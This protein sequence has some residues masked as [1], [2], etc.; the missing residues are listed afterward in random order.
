MINIPLISN[1]LNE[2]AELNS[3][4]IAVQ[5]DEIELT[6]RQLQEIVNSRT[7]EIINN[8]FDKNKIIGVVANHSLQFIIDLFAIWNVGASVFPINIT[9]SQ[10][11]INEQLN[12]IGCR[13]LDDPIRK[14]EESDKNSAWKKYTSGSNALL[15][16]TSGSTGQFKVVQHTFQSLFSSANSIDKEI[17]FSPN[18]KWLASLPFYRIGGFQ[19]IMRAMLS[20]GTICIPKQVKTEEINLGISK[21][22]P[23]YISLV[24]ASIPSLLENEEAK[25]AKAIFLGG[26]PV[27]SKILETGLEKSLP[28][29]KVYGSTET[30]SMITILNLK[31]HK[32]KID[33]AGQ[34]VPGVNIKIE[35]D[36]VLV[37]SESLFNEYYRNHELTI[38]RLTGDWYYT[39]DSG[40]L[41]KEGFLYIKGRID[42]LIVSGG[43]KIDPAEI[44]MTLIGLESIKSA[45]VFGIPDDKWGEKVCAAILATDELDFDKLKKI[46][47]KYLSAYKIPKEIKKVDHFPVDEMGKLDL[48]KLRKLFE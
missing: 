35:D 12:F 7:H 39:G 37:K 15:M 13:V 48:K 5:T 36:E 34:V 20:G 10:N 19:I 32:N 28:L 22:K 46:L 2:Q 33:S 29:Y 24:N 47:K 17:N 31:K 30:G 25:S 9:L 16:F 6:F 11:E 1:W 38:Q 44:E 27:D 42:N 40:Y 26:G 14:A 18:E 3:N 4:L 43:E 23:Q 8:R 41:D 21:Y 45:K